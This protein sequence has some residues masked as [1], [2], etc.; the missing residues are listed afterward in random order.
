MALIF[1]IAFEEAEDGA[2][3]EENQDGEAGDG[4]GQASDLLVDGTE[5]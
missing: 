3:A 5:M 4:D 2:N 1:L